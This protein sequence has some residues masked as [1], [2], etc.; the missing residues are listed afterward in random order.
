MISTGTGITKLGVLP[1]Q[2]VKVEP[3]GLSKLQSSVATATA[4]TKHTSWSVAG[5][6]G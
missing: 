1:L 6:S 2:E 5:G 3:R 4:A